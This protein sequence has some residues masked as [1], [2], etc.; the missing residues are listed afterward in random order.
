MAEGTRSHE[1]TPLALA[2]RHDPRS[3]LLRL[4]WPAIVAHQL[5]R[6]RRVE[7]ADE[8][9]PLEQRPTEPTRVASAGDVVA[10]AVSLR[11]CARARVA[12][13]DEHDRRGEPE[14]LLAPHDVDLAFLQRLAQRFQRSS[15][16][17]GKLVEEED[18]AVSEG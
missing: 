9:D 3:D 8:V 5:E 12:G 2:R 10:V 15:R 17:L 18:A 1:T 7:L 4:L 6:S 13:T 16:E 11:P 14:R